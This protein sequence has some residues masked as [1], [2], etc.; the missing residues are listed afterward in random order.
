MPFKRFV[1]NLALSQDSKH[2]FAKGI[3]VEVIYWVH[4]IMQQPFISSLWK[5]LAHEQKILLTALF[6]PF[7]L[8]LLPIVQYLV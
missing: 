6:A 8:L 4:S 2:W 1:E 5:F 7:P 3:T